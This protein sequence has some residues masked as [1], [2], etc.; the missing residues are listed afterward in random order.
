MGK[1]AARSRED[2]SGRTVV[3]LATLRSRNGDEDEGHHVCGFRSWEAIRHH[4]NQPNPRR[5]LLFKTVEAAGRSYPSGVQCA[6]SEAPQREQVL[7]MMAGTTGLRRSELIALTWQDVDFDSLQIEIKRHACVVRSGI[8][9]RRTAQNLF[10]CSLKWQPPSG[11]GKR[12][13]CI[14]GRGI[15]SSCPFGQ[16]E[17]FPCGLTLVLQKVIRPAAERAGIRGKVIGWHTF[18][19]SHAT[20]LRSLGVDVETAQELL[21]HANSRIATAAAPRF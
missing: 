6:G 5:P 14:P 3:A 19:H 1:C 16:R 21:R 12:S 18:R 9:K 10:R 13:P 17:R 8:P 15:S 11:N 4:A 20:N 2:C 7:V